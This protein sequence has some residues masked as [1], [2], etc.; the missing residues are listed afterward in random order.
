M[1]L[2]GARGVVRLEGT[3]ASTAGLLR[4]LPKARWAHIA[5]HGFFA[6]PAVP[7]VLR[8]DPKLFARSGRDRAAPVVRNPLVLSGLVLA[9]AN[10]PSADIDATTHDDLGILTAEAI[11]GMPLQDLELVVL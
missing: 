11:A 8:P 4:A 9:G 3:A 2:A 6:D 5:T 10:R 7:S 1:H